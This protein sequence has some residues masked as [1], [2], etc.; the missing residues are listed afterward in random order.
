MDRSYLKGFRESTPS[1][2]EDSNEW[3]A[4][5][6]AMLCRSLSDQNQFLVRSDNKNLQRMYQMKSIKLSEGEMKYLLPSTVSFPDYWV[7]ERKPNGKSVV[8]QATTGDEDILSSATA[9]KFLLDCM[10]RRAGGIF[11]L[12]SNMTLTH[13]VFH[14]IVGSKKSIIRLQEE[15]INGRRTYMTRNNIALFKEALNSQFRQPRPPLISFLLNDN[16][17]LSIS[18]NSFACQ[19]DT[20]LLELTATGQIDPEKSF[21]NTAEAHSTYGYPLLQFESDGTLWN[22]SPYVTEYFD[23]FSEEEPFHNVK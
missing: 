19:G 8:I 5:I 17:T 13:D 4:I 6:G 23:Y 14:R 22:N 7:T 9:E 21:L 11:V 3:E 15:K 1:I 2:K 20:P 16:D 12:T 10:M 18:P